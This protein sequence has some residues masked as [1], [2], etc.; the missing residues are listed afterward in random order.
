MMISLLVGLKCKL[1]KP[2]RVKMHGRAGLTYKEN[3]RSMFVDCELL[4]DKGQHGICIYKDS[5]KGW[6]NP[7]D[8]QALDDVERRRILIN[9]VVHFEKLGYTVY[10]CPSY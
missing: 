10:V 6:K 4:L 3:E 9:I 1:K 7:H 8:N 2:Y 5:I